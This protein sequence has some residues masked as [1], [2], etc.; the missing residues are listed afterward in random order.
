MPFISPLSFA[1]RS[2]PIL[3][4]GELRHR[5]ISNLPRV[6][7]VD[8]DRQ[9]P[10]QHPA[11]NAYPHNQPQLQ[12]AAQ[13]APGRA[14]LGGDL[15]RRSILTFWGTKQRQTGTGKTPLN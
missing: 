7:Q 13:P 1:S 4:M 11:S 9:L 6:T 14:L 15:N 8:S 10:T 12:E 5:G 3:Q 2:V